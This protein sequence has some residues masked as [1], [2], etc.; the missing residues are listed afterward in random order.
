MILT[1]LKIKSFRCFK[2][3]AFEFHPKFNFIAGAN[4]SGKTALLEAISL[5]STGR[6]FRLREIIPLIHTD[7]KEMNLFAELQNGHTVSLRKAIAASSQIKINSQPCLR[8]SE[9][10]TFLPSQVI[11]QDLFEIIDAGPNVRR[12]LLDWGLF[13]VKHDYHQHLFQYRQALKQR[14]MLLKTGAKPAAFKPW[15]QT[16]SDLGEWIH[17]ARQ[18]YIEILIP[19]FKEKLNALATFTSEIN[20]FKGWGKEN[21]SQ[22]LQS[23]LEQ[24]YATDI[25]KQYTQLGPHQADL[26]LTT[27]TGKAK[28]YLSRGQQKIVLLTLKL[29]QAEILAKPCL[30]IWDDV[31]SEIDGVHIEKL[32]S[33]IHTLPGQFFITGISFANNAMPKEAAKLINL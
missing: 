27:T 2:D 7:E 31:C 6:S 33:I 3:K 13:H 18:E 30:Y 15:N 26:V 1:S 20:Y 17:S 8:T 19:I 21:N 12:Q 11:Y 10:T 24:N 16:I 25:Y 9:L 23:A 29:A 32:S 4:G 5:L 28:H 22:T 14:N